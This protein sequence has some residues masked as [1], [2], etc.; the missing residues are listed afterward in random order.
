MMHRHIIRSLVWLTV[1]GLAILLNPLTSV[2]SREAFTQVENYRLGS[3]PGFTRIL[4]QLNQDSA[5]RLLFSAADAKAVL[6]IRNATLNPKVQSNAFRDSRLAEIQVEEIQKNV[7]FTFRLKGRDTGSVLA[8]VIRAGRDPHEH[9]ASLLMRIDL[10]TFQELKESDLV[11]YK[12]ARQR[13][14]AVNFGVPGGLGAVSLSQY[15]RLTYGVELS[16]DEAE[17]FRDRFLYDIYPE[18]GEYM[19]SDLAEILAQ[20]L[21]VPVR[22]VKK[23]WPDAGLLSGAK[24]IVQ[25]RTKK[26]ASGA[27]RH[28]RPGSAP[29]AR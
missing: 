5:Y 15:A 17:E 29:K 25:G 4:I 7:K 20:N 21:R 1:L 12:Q 6:W 16:E 24:N 10:A 3:H 23:A 27:G 11:Q 2:E 22:N 13:A 28:A 9:T 19:E 18:I 26:R 8:D 14:K